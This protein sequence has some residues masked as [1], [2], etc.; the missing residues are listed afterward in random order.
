MA[1]LLPLFAAAAGGRLGVA[2]G[3]V[4]ILLPLFA[5]TAGVVAGAELHDHRDVSSPNV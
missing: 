4:A 1:I 2:A 5:A 3:V